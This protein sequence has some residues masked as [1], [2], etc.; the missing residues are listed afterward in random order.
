MARPAQTTPTAAHSVPESLTFRMR[1][2]TTA[3]TASEAAS[4]APTA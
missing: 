4:A 2:A 3:V 1:A